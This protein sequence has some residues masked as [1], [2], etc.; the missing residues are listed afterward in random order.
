MNDFKKLKVWERS[1]NL[2]VEIYKLTNK[3]PDEERFGL[4]AQ[5][6]RASISIPSNI[7]EGAGRNS[8]KEFN[9]FL[10]YAGGSSCE[11]ESQLIIAEKLNYVENK[12][13]EI[14]NKEVNEIRSM[15]FG[16]KNS[17]NTSN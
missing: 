5:L 8:N 7:A 16:L 12:D 13:L 2:T 6:R 3:F 17:L 4:V 10:G 14:I 9:N 1:I 15:I 11:I